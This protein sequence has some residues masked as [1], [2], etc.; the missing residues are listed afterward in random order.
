MRLSAGTILF[1]VAAAGVVLYDKIQAGENL[2]PKLKALKVNTIVF[3]QPLSL[4]TIFSVKNPTDA[5]ISLNGINGMLYIND[6][7]FSTLN[8]YQVAT[9][10]AKGAIDYSVQFSVSV[11]NTVTQII[12]LI[13]NNQPLKVRF[14]GS[15]NAEG[16]NIP[17]DEVVTT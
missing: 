1:L 2:S 15:I 8:S 16:I 5:S 14:S 6:V 12:S 3:G 10:P 9:V 4:S 7:L 13:Q 17:I 11:N